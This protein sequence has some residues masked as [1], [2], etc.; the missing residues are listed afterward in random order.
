MFSH[1]NVNGFF[2][3]YLRML[4]RGVLN[5]RDCGDILPQHFMRTC[6]LFNSQ[7]RNFRQFCRKKILKLFLVDILNCLK[8][9]TQKI[10]VPIKKKLL[11]ANQLD[12]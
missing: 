11:T 5:W 12:K 8:K 4:V 6:I 3:N 10:M 2:Q 7:N 9:S 1:Q